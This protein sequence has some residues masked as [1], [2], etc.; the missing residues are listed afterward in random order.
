M[1][2][3]NFGRNLRENNTAAFAR[4]GDW[5]S[6]G[7]SLLPGASLISAI[8]GGDPLGPNNSIAFRDAASMGPPAPG[9]SAGPAR[10][11]SSS[12]FDRWAARRGRAAT[13]EA[14]PEAPRDAGEPRILTSAQE[15]RDWMGHNTYGG[16]ADRA[17]DRGIYG[18]ARYGS[19]GSSTNPLIS[20]N[21]A[22]G[23]GRLGANN[24]PWRQSGMTFG[25]RPSAQ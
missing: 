25:V 8:R 12:A 15:L 20:G 24:T 21:A 7:L 1:P 19:G 14:A 2:F 10:R 23:L 5:R 3:Q 9:Q 13:P 17:V 6:A 4:R 16:Y 18:G 11:S 22:G